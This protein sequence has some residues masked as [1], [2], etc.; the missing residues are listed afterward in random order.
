MTSARG[1][2][3]LG[4]SPRRPPSGSHRYPVKLALATLAFL[5]FAAAATAQTSWYVDASAASPGNGTQAAPYSSLQYA[6]DQ[7]T[8]VNGDTLV[9]ASGVYAESIDLRG[10]ALVVDGSA[11]TPS[12][13][14]DGT[15]AVTVVVCRTG[16]GAGTVLRGLVVRNGVA[17]PMA[18]QG[19]GGGAWLDGTSPT[20][21]G[22][23]FEANAALFGGAVAIR[24]GAPTFIDCRF[25]DNR[26]SQQGGALFV[27]AGAVTVQGGTLRSNRA[28]VGGNTPGR[29]GALCV[30]A[31]GTANVTGATFDSNRAHLS[32]RGGAVA[33]LSGSVGTAL[34]DSHFVYNTTSLFSWPG[35][36]GAVS[37]EGPLTALRCSFLQNGAASPIGEFDGTLY[38]GAAMGGTYT[39]C[40]FVGNSAQFGGAL[41]NSIAVGCEFRQNRACA[42]GSGHGGAAAVCQLTDCLLIDNSACGD[43]GGASGS[44]LVDCEVLHNRATPGSNGLGGH[45]GGLYAGSATGCVLRGNSTSNPQ[46]Y[47]GGAFGTTLVRCFITSNRADFGGGVGG[48]GALRPSVDRCTIVGNQANFGGGGVGDAADVRN[49][50]VWHNFGGAASGN[51]S[52]A[53]SAVEGGALG[54]GNIALDPLLLGPAGSDAHFGLGSPCIDAADPLAPLDPDGSRADMG[55]APFDSNWVAAPAPYCTVTRPNNFPQPICLPQIEALGA[56]SVSGTSTV[57][58]IGTSINPGQLGILLIGRSAVRVNLVTSPFGQTGTLCIGAPYVRGRVQSATQG[59]PCSGALGQPITAPVLAFLGVVPGERLHAQYWFRAGS[60]TALTDA[61]EIPIVP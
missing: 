31:G 45:G 37:G 38:G 40:D 7:A 57:Q 50:I 42:D 53:Y 39:D 25:I 19:F 32:G 56:A 48:V 14:L 16:E 35:M 17:T 27:E 15:S 28:A 23:T 59:S 46:S 34:V 61:L 58:V 30:A 13:V 36:A 33:A 5:T 11:A 10:K 43:G 18:G 55:A 47:G 12:P 8:T 60:G 54:V 41:S 2:T 51:V 6:I 52:F 21:E 24:G 4:A 1:G 49:S 9:V 44:S 26:A 3:T 22:V 29:G 20:F